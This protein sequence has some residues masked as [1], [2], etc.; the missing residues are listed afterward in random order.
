MMNVSQHCGNA[1][2]RSNMHIFRSR[3]VTHTGSRQPVA[4]RQSPDQCK[5]I[6]MISTAS[7][8]SLIGAHEQQGHTVLDPEP[9]PSQQPQRHA[10][11]RMWIAVAL[12]ATSCAL[13]HPSEALASAVTTAGTSSVSPLAGIQIRITKRL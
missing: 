9:E 2:M 11:S 1:Q 10:T 4:T 6:S 5:C 7:S 13:L 3:Y 8:S 12:L